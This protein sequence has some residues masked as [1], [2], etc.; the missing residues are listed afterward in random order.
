MRRY[1]VGI[2]PAHRSSSSM[3]YR[4]LFG[5]HMLLYCAPGHPLHGAD[6]A[7]LDWSTLQQHAF[8]GLGYHSP[9]WKSRARWACAAQATGFDQEAIATLDSNGLLYRLSARALWALA[10]STW[11]PAGHCARALSRTLP[12]LSPCGACP[13]AQPCRTD[14]DSMPGN[15][16]MRISFGESNVFCYA[17]FTCWHNDLRKSQQETHRKSLLLE[18]ILFRDERVFCSECPVG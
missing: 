5:E 4:D 12:V 16:S 17:S 2:I 3:V 13:P 9:R 11:P 10:G 6:H 18:S 14:H 1:Q 15:R 8:A 7:L